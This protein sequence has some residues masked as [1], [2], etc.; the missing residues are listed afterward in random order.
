MY[1]RFGPSMDSGHKLHR[2]PEILSCP[3]RIDGKV[4]SVDNNLLAIGV[5]TRRGY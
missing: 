2:N 1:L 4:P 5:P 3:R